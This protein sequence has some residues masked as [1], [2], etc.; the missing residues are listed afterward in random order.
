M[1]TVQTPQRIRSFA[2]LEAVRALRANEIA[3]RRAECRANPCPIFAE[4]WLD[5][6]A[7]TASVRTD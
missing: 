5:D 3:L 6:I 2:D 7:L 4:I 1:T